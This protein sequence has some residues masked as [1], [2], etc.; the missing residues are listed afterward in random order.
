MTTPSNL[1]IDT[2]ASVSLVNTKLVAQVGGMEKISPTNIVIAGLD[3]VIV[4]TKGEICLPI[5]FGNMKIQHTFVVCNELEH[6]FLVGM[7]I[8]TNHKITLDIPNAN[9][10]TPMGKENFIEKPVS[11]KNRLKVRCAKTKVI[12][13]LTA[14]YLLGKIPI[15]GG[16]S[17]FEGMVEPRLKLAEE[18]GVIVSGTLSYTDKNLVPIR[19]MNVMPYDV[20]IYRNQLIAFME[21][22]EKFNGIHSVQKV[23]TENRFYDSRINLP[24][25]PSAEPESET[26][27]NGKWENPELLFQQLKIDELDFSDELKQQLKDLIA[28]FSHCFSRNRFD[29][30]KASFYEA[31]ITLNKN[32]TPKWVPIREIPYK[33]QDAMTEEIDNMEKAGL[34]ERTRYS[35]WNSAVMLVSKGPGKPPRFVQDCRALGTQCVQ[36]NYQISN[37]STILDKIT[38]CNYLTKLDFTSSFNQLSLQEK[39]KNLTAFSYNGDRYQWTRLVQ[40]HKSSSSQF[41]RCMAQLFSQVPFGSDLLIYIDDLVLGSRTAE[42]HLKRLRFILERLSWGNLKLSPTKCLFMRR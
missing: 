4:P 38:E 26:R 15:R 9:L 16:K 32:Y 23:N 29:L 40:G 7:D 36:D 17:N 27:K 10:Y 25:L 20:T 6:D 2:G 8:L 18:K 37:I 24:R 31:R 13:A 11:L 39:S 3:N 35:L 12:P 34:I 33:L 41:S 19:Y 1:L 5:K 21:P 28:E 14:G 30:G 42:E 22:F